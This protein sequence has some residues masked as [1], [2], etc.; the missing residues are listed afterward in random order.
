MIDGRLVKG[1]RI[2]LKNQKFIDHRGWL[3]GMGFFDTWETGNI[4]V[5]SDII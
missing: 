3:I 2:S 4:S 5:N 1:D